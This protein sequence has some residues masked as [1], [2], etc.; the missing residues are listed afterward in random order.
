MRIVLA[1]KFDWERGTVIYNSLNGDVL[2]EATERCAE[3]CD[4]EQLAQMM[5]FGGYQEYEL[6][7]A[8]EEAGDAEIIQQWFPVTH[9]HRNDLL[10]PNED[11]P[12]CSE[13]R[14]A[15]LSDSDMHHLADRIYGEAMS[16]AFWVGLEW[17]IEQNY[18]EL[19][20][21]DEEREALELEDEDA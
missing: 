17:Q 19:L 13:K 6:R 10:G 14:V 3:I 11:E 4:P 8:S 18:P 2:F 12:W 5:V 9:L 20:L 21:T 16:E 1:A 7:Y 15:A